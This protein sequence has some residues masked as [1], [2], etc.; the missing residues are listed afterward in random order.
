M[1]SRILKDDQGNEF[2]VEFDDDSGGSGGGDAAEFLDIPQEAFEWLISQYNE[3]KEAAR[4]QSAGSSSNGQQRQ[5]TT[6][7][8]PQIRILP[9]S[10]DSSSQNGGKQTQSGR[11]KVLKLRQSA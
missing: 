8:M 2:E 11:R 6:P 3:A 9:K 10:A 4:R 7:K 1:A 5:T